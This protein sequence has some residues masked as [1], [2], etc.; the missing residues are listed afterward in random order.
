MPHGCYG[1]PMKTLQSS[2][3]LTLT[4]LLLLVFLP[5]DAQSTRQVSSVSETVIHASQLA[6]RMQS[7]EADIAMT[8]RVNGV[9]REAHGK[10]TLAKPNLARIELRGDYPELQLVSDGYTRYLA[11]SQTQ[12][13][14]IP[15]DPQG[16]GIDSPWWGLPFRFF[17][18]QSVNPFGAKSDAAAT[19]RDTGAFEKNGLRLHGVQARGSSPMGPY[20]ETLFFD[21]AGDLIES[22][23][24][25]GE[26]AAAAV[27]SAA[28]THIRHARRASDSFRFTP[29]PGQ[30]GANEL[31]RLLAIGAQAPEFTL[32][33]AAGNSVSLVQARSGKRAVLVNFWYYNCAPCRVEFP[34]FEKLYEQFA[35]QGFTIIAVDKGDAPATVRGYLRR[36]GLQFPV[37]LGGANSKGSVFDR[38]QV[39]DLYPVS[40]LLDE[41]G[42]VVFHSVGEDIVGL[43]KALGQLGVR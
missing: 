3:C 35:T 32:P 29:L 24:Q 2:L 4:S 43:K 15:I 38:Y 10:I 7:M 5:T 19:F 41:R 25:F 30:I 39:E 8:W 11:A 33:D 37:V 16:E 23:I 13:E 20:V 12:Y 31:D 34:E 36:A 18:A 40:Y 6:Q 26:G 42:A 9:T 28:I 21:A 1:H 17:F 22:R 27:F 14:A